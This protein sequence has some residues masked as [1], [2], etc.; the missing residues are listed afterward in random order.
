MKGP[1]LV[2]A[3]IQHVDGMCAK[4]ACRKSITIPKKCTSVPSS[5]PIFMNLHMPGEDGT[6]M[7]LHIES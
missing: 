5:Y 2:E 1:A 4:R 6:A 3:W 7:S